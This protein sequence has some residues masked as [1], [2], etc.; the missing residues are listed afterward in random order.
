MMN[1]Y[2]FILLSILWFVDEI[3]TIIDV[4]KYGINREANPVAKY[5]L[6]H[7]KFAFTMFKIITLALFY[8][9]FKYVERYDVGM[10]TVILIIPILAYFIVDIRNFEI[11]I[12][13][14]K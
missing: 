12:G 4:K 7:G 1:F 14:I 2:L 8:L 11:M 3:L 9:M 10:G 13:K 6:V 5:F